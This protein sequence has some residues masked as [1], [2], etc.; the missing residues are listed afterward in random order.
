MSKHLSLILITILCGGPAGASTLSLG[1]EKAV[2][3]FN[4]QECRPQ[5]AHDANHDE[6]L[7]AWRVDATSS[8]V[9]LVQWL[10]SDGSSVTWSPS[11]DL[12]NPRDAVQA[13][14]AWDPVDEVYLVVWSKDYF[15][16]ASDWDIYG[17]IIGRGDSAN[18]PPPF[19]IA[20][21]GF[22]EWNPR[23]AFSE[24]SG[25]FLV[26][27][28]AEGS[29][30]TDDSVHA[31]RVAPAGN[32]LNSSIA[33]STGTGDSKYPDIAY[34]QSRDEYLIVFQHMGG[35]WDISGTRLTGTGAVVGSGTFGIAEWSSPETLP[36]VASIPVDDEW[37]IVWQSED[38][39][40]DT[41][42]YARRMW[43][44]GSG[45]NHFVAPVLISNTTSPERAPDIAAY[46]EG[47]EYLVSYEARYTNLHYG[48]LAKTLDT[49][50]FMGPEIAVILPVSE[51]DR[52]ASAIAAFDKGWMVVWEHERDSTPSYKDIHARKVYLPI[53]S[54]GFESGSIGRWS[55]SNP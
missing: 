44:D 45:N 11:E 5:V 46:P 14:V 10:H 20:Q 35:S 13:A 23:V 30:T 37:G 6:F 39:T 19:F 49:V 29:G 17:Q 16:D 27:W 21:T 9:V 26:T 34:N 8:S 33:V 51:L 32:L 41:A 3:V 25:E 53:F 55:G 7:F 4:Y 47:N 18:N 52:T 42:I 15:G 31:Q 12:S 43:V 38:N 1:N 28:W 40:G 22:N 36:R 2:S 50:N 24:T 48:V 54:D